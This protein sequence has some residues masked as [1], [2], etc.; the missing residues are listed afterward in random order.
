MRSKTKGILIGGLSATLL[1]GG[2]GAVA[3]L[4]NGFKDTNKVR[5]L[6]KTGTVVEK[7][8][9]T[10]DDNYFVIKEKS[11]EL[12]GARLLSVDGIVEETIQ[13]FDDFAYAIDGWEISSKDMNK[14]WEKISVRE[15]AYGILATV[16]FHVAKDEQVDT[17]YVEIPYFDTIRVNY[18][19]DTASLIMSHSSNDDSEKDLLTSWNF[20]QNGENLYQEVGIFEGKNVADTINFGAFTVDAVKD[21]E[22]EIQS[23]ELVNKTKAKASDVLYM[24]DYANHI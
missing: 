10:D 8:V 21:F 9:F 12:E 24:Y 4:T 15:K 22:L 6:T 2:L 20:T 17:H 13:S 5:E 16:N 3:Y 14:M 7:L 11:S 23:I 19:I 18:K 1:L